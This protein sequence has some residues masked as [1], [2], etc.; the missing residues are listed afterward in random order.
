MEVIPLV[1]E[2]LSSFYAEPIVVLD[3][4]VPNLNGID[5]AVVE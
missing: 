2:P 4:Q 1:M 5:R 3:F